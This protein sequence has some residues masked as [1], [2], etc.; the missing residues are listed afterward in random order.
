MWFCRFDIVIGGCDISASLFF[1]SFGLLDGSFLAFCV[2]YGHS[3]L[4]SVFSPYFICEFSFI[5]SDF[6]VAVSAVLLFM[7]V[8]VFVAIFPV[9][10]FYCYGVHRDLH[11]FPTLLSSDLGSQA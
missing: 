2:L 6:C 11:A 4:V 8:S 5:S 9:F 3:W 1:L 7:C 10:F